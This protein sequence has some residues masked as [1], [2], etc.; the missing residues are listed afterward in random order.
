MNK[1]SLPKKHRK[2]LLILE[3]IEFSDLKEKRV[4][5]NNKTSSKIT[6]PKNWVNKKVY[7]ALVE[8]KT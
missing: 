4:I 6:L 1:K 8:D 5:K 2:G 7:V 3:H